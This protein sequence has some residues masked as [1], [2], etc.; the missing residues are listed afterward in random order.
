MASADATSLKGLLS[1]ITGLVNEISAAA[2]KQKLKQC[3]F[4]ADSP[5]ELDR[6]PP[7]FHVKREILADLCQDMMWLVQGPKH[8]VV[9]YN[10]CV[11][12]NHRMV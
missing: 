1:K 6:L 12:V 11:R 3:T 8:S 10:S 7:Q 9:T 4:E 5:D 2:D